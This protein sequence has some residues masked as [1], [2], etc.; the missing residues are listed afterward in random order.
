MGF[1][2]YKEIPVWKKSHQIVLEI[3]ELSKSFPTEEKFGLTSQI[4]RSAASCPAN[5]VEGFYKNTTKELILHLYHARGS[6][7]ET[8]YHLL[9]AKDLKYINP[10]TFKKLEKQID[11]II[12]QL[13]NWIKSLK[14]K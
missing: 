14:N 3:Y 2:N 1:K 9:L 7:G 12:K 13:N 4:R 10:E 5:I 8:I 6:S 11:D